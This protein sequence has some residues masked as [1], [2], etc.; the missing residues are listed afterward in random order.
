MREDLVIKVPQYKSLHVKYLFKFVAS[1]LNIFKNLL[2]YEY[3][4][5]L[6]REW[7]CNLFNILIGK[8]SQDFIKEKTEIRKHKLF[9]SKNL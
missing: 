6:N 9:E 5:E 4:R 3:N 8:D 2:D 7:L 1:K